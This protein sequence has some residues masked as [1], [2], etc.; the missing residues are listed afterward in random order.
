M[1]TLIEKKFRNLKNFIQLNWMS[2]MCVYVNIRNGPCH[3]TQA[4]KNMHYKLQFKTPS[5]CC[6]NHVRGNGEI[7][8]K[9]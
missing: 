3:D 6:A 5:F 7:R 8:N 1:A 4:C 2:F 9:C